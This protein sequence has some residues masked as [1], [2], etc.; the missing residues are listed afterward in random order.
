[1]AED[2]VAVVYFDIEDD[3]DIPIASMNRLKTND[4]KWLMD[5]PDYIFDTSNEQGIIKNE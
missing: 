5:Y 2:G 4:I 3:K 1:V